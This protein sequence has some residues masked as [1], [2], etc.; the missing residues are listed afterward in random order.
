LLLKSKE[1]RKEICEIS[2]NGNFLEI[3][4]TT[5]QFFT[6]LRPGKEKAFH[7]NRRH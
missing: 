5:Y 2:S 4:L 1:Y 6:S 7:K 3:W